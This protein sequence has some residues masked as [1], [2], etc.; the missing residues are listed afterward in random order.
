[1]GRMIVLY[2]LSAFWGVIVFG[3]AIRDQVKM[4][5]EHWDLIRFAESKPYEKRKQRD[6]YDEIK[7]KRDYAKEQAYEAGIREDRGI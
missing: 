3:F 4:Y 2:T 5:R 6:L 1:M 7:I